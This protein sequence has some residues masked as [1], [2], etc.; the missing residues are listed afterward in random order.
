MCFGAAMSCFIGEIVYS[1]RAPDDGII[2]LLNSDAFEGGLVS[3]QIPLLRGRIL[4]NESKRLIQEYCE[5][6]KKEY[7]RSFAATILNGN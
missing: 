3:R 7:L 6:E 1:L 4:S 5:Y 2:R